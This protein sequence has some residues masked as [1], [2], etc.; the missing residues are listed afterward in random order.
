MFIGFVISP[1]IIGFL[2]ALWTSGPLWS[3]IMKGHCDPYVAHIRF[4]YLLVLALSLLSCRA[5]AFALN[6]VS[7]A[8]LHRCFFCSFPFWEG[9]LGV[10]WRQ[11]FT[12][13]LEHKY[14]V[15]IPHS[16]TTTNQANRNQTELTKH[17]IIFRT[18]NKREQVNGG[19]LNT[20]HVCA[21]PSK[22][23]SCVRKKKSAVINQNE[24]ENYVKRN[25]KEQTLTIYV[26]ILLL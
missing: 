18:S 25:H 3:A 19:T 9:D 20:S 22:S 7:C 8:F 26:V 21:W 15:Y 11:L 16:G 6:T 17:I 5:L 24:K 13:A 14:S 2:P 1:F 10:G 12:H 23:K 4:C